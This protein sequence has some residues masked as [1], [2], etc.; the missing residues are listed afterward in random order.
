MMRINENKDY[1]NN[2]NDLKQL[3]IGYIEDISI[4]NDEAFLKLRRDIAE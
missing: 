3:I 2:A 1:F 4:L